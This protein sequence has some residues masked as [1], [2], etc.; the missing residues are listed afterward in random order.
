VLNC[1]SFIASACLFLYSLLCVRLYFG[2][3]CYHNNPILHFLANECRRT[4]N[5]V[6]DKYNIE[7]YQITSCSNFEIKKLFWL[8]LTGM[9]AK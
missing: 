6:A 5:A 2:K 7:P 3:I 4:V 8:H 9:V 1:Y